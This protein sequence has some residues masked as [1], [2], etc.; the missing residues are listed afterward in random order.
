M[1]LN[2][3]EDKA[4]P[5]SVVVPLAVAQQRLY[6]TDQLGKVKGVGCV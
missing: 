4:A 5:G 3:Q 1:A 6:A 2:P